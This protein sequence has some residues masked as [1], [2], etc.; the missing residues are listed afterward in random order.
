[1]A[2]Y[3]STNNVDDTPAFYVNNVANKKT[4]TQLFIKLN[5]TNTASYQFLQILF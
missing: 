4:S 1:M 5:I 3:C 2:R